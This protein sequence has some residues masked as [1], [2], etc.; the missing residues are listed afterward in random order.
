MESVGS[1]LDETVVSSGQ[2][3]GCGRVSH[4]IYRK[5]SLAKIMDHLLPE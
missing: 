5:K 4:T 3:S 1:A 2:N